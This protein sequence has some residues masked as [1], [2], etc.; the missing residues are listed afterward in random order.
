MDKKILIVLGLVVFAVLVVSLNGKITGNYFVGSPRPNMQ[1]CTDS[2]GGNDPYVQG[3][4]EYKGFSAEMMQ[5]SDSCVN[6]GN[7]LEHSCEGVLHRTETIPCRCEDGAC[8][9]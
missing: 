6:A 7:L 2:D 5:A 1:S 4:V 9:K 3:S 8:K